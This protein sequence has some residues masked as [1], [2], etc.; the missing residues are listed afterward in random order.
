MFNAGGIKRK[1][2][3]CKSCEKIIN[4]KIKDNTSVS[5][6]CIINRVDFDKL[7]MKQKNVCAIC[8]KPESRM[9]KGTLSKLSVDHCHKKGHIRGLLCTKCNSGIG[10]L[11]D[12][13]T[14]L[15]RAI[16]YLK[17]NV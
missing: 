16:N 8:S 3:L 13:C 4:E 14:I 9:V 2:P 1:N 6:R 7:L 12:S 15:E 11:Q 5:T 10:L 17:K